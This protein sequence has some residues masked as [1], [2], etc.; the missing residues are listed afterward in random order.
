MTQPTT[1]QSLTGTYLI[2]PA[3]SRLGFVARHAMV[4]M[5]RHGFGAVSL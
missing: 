2:D 1:T 4:T 3:H 5:K